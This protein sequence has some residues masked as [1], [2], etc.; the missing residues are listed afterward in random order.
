MEVFISGNVP[1][2]KN[3]KQWTGKFLVS[4]KTVKSYLKKKGIKSYS[5]THKEVKGYKCMPNNFEEEIKP[6][7]N[8]IEQMAR[9]VTI[10]FYFIRD[11]KRKFDYINVVQ[12]IL[13]L[14]TAH[15]IIEDDNADEVI[16][17]FFGYHVDKDNA[18]VKIII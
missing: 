18:G 4:S 2:L 10:G 12:I 5:T 3:S 15:G 1:S 9:P 13:D 7:L 6:F 16:P 17:Q 14:M 11:S 8:V